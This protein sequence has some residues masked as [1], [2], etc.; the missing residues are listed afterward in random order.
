VKATIVLIGQS[1]LQSLPCAL[2]LPVRRCSPGGGAISNS[3]GS[4]AAVCVH[5]ATHALRKP[6]ARQ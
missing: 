6:L 5:V 3:A 2:H 1:A 4:L